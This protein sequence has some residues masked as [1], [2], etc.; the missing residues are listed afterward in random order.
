VTHVWGQ[1]HSGYVGAVGG[2]A[3]H[4]DERGNVA[5]LDHAPNKDTALLTPLARISA[6]HRASLATTY[7]VVAGAQHC[8]VAGD[9]HRRN[10]HIVLRDELVTALVL[11]QVPDTHCPGAIATDQFALIGVYDYVV[12]SAA[13]IVVPLHAA[14]ACVPDLDGS[15][16][17][18]GDHPLALAVKGDARD[19]AGVALKGQHGGR[20]G[21]LD[22]VELDRMVARGGKIALVGGDA[23]P[24]DLRVRVWYGA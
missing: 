18:R 11:A 7:G 22:V 8:P 24:V 16:F 3:A 19:I 2:E 20:V 6:P 12:D 17:G 14:A 5:V 21:G 9:S 23:E 15:V 1:E 13:M 4:G 10:R